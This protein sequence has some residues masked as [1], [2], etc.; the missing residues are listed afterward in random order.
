[1]KLK[2]LWLYEELIYRLCHIFSGISNA[3][4]DKH[5]D[6]AWKIR[7]EMH[8]ENKKNGNDLSDSEK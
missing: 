5:K 7:M 1:M 2:L 8:K 4:F 3:L 6:I